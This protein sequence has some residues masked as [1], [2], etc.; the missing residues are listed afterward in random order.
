MYRLIFGY[1]TAWFLRWPH[2]QALPTGKR[3]ASDGMLGGAWEQGYLRALK[4]YLLNKAYNCSIKPTTP[5]QIEM[6][7]ILRPWLII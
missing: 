1:F 7:I 6:Q 3:T 2:F 5:Q 4:N